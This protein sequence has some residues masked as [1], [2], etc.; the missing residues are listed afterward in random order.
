MSPL[1]NTVKSVV[2][3]GFL[4]LSTLFLLWMAYRIHDLHRWYAAN[5]SD[6]DH[7]PYVPLLVAVVSLTTGFFLVRTKAWPVAIPTA[8]L[9]IL[10]SY[11]YLLGTIP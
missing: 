4:T 6:G 11:A 10:L 5:G 3:Y 9:V 8:V 7:F 1:Q 2:S